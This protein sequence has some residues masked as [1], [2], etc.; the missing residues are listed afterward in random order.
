MWRCRQA[1]EERDWARLADLMHRNF[2][3]RRRIFGDAV[4]GK[5]NIKMVELARSV[6]GVLLSLCLEHRLAVPL[7]IISWLKLIMELQGLLT[8]DSR[9]S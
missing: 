9:S 8:R 4:L 7:A 5:V 2:D 1:I 6:G 3:M